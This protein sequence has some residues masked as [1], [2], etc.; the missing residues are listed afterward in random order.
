MLAAH[1]PTDFDFGSSG[2]SLSLAAMRN[3]IPQ[4]NPTRIIRNVGVYS[5]M[6]V[7]MPDDV[8]VGRAV[9]VSSIG[10][11]AWS[12]SVAGERREVFL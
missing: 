7:H 1:K 5:S 3:R 4:E 2:S 9:D 11:M 12:G 8:L 6:R 10:T